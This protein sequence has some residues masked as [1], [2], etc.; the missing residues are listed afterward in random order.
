MIEALLNAKPEDVDYIL[1]DAVACVVTVDEHER[2]KQ[3]D[4]EYGWERY[5]KAGIEAF[6]MVTGERK[7]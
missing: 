6:D 5:R 3:F 1:K 7:F 2:L 4:N